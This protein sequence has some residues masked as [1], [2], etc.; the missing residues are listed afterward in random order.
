MPHIMREWASSIISN[1][2]SKRRNGRK[3]VLLF[4][5]H[6]FPIPFEVL[7]QFRV[8]DILT[9][10]IPD[11]SSHCLQP[12]EVHIVP[13]FTCQLRRELRNAIAETHI[14]SGTRVGEMITTTYLHA[15]TSD[16]IKGGFQKTGAWGRCPPEQSSLQRS[17][18]RS[19]S[20]E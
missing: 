6:Y 11:K 14:L 19:N 20:P 15:V 4:D 12:L 1:T 5:P 8:N 2:R 17:P 13:K 16:N 9:I 7:D 3:E 10:A 18:P